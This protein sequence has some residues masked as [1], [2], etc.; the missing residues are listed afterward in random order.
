MTNEG[1]RKNSETNRGTV[2]S[3]RTTLLRRPWAGA[4]IFGMLAIASLAFVSCEQQSTPR[5]R[6]TVP[7]STATKSDAADN[8]IHIKDFEFVPVR[9]KVPVGTQ[10]IWI[11]DDG[12]NHIIGDSELNWRVGILPPGGSGSFQ[13]D[14]PGEHTYVC[15]IH[16]NMRGT[17]V[18]Q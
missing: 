2:L 7:V 10:V 17:L 16:A 4:A 5:K 13:F 1:W 8:V 12:T 3:R 15:S 18:V 11:N 6:S 14:N 9:L